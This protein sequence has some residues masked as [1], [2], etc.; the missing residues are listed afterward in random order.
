MESLAGPGFGLM[1]AIIT[2]LIAIWAIISIMLP[3]FVMGINDKVG[4]IDRN[5]AIITKAI[6][7]M[8]KKNSPSDV[9][10]V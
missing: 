9:T 1:M 10:K 8:T 2:I 7:G 6:E 3:F 5:I 4:R